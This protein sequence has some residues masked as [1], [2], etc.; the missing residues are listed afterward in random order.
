MKK[1]IMAAAMSL[2]ATTAMA[3]GLST[4]IGAERATEAEVNTLFGSVGYGMLSLGATMADT[5][6]D[7]GEFNITKYEIDLVQPIGET[8]VSVNMKNDFDDGFNH[9]ETVIGG[10]ITF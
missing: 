1:V 10:K 7:Q 5:S 4:T 8:G 6:A 9:S 3:E 2:A